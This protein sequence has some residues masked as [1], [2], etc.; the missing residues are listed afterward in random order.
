MDNSIIEIID[1]L[2]KSEYYGAGESVELAKGKHEIAST[3]KQLKTK[4]KRIIKS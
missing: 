1:V 3:W 4:V 2:K